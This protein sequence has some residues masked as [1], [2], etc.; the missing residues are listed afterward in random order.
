MASLETLRLHVP[1][2]ALDAFAAA[3]ETAC[4]SVGFFLADEDARLWCVEGVKRPGQ[5]EAELA[6][7]LAIASLVTG[8]QPTLQRSPVEAGGWLER[9]RSAFPEQ[10]VG[11]RFA[12][13]GTHLPPGGTPGRITLVLDAGVAFGSGEHAS[14]RGC[15]RALERVAYRRPAHILDLGC[16]SG[17]LAM[18]ASRLLHRCVLATDIDR[19]SV[20]VA[21]D[22]AARNRL[23]NRVRCRIAAGW[24]PNARR[25]APY[26]LIFANI[27][28]RP[29]CAMARPLAEALA[30][31]GTAILSGL[32][33]RQSRMVLSAHRRVGLALDFNLVEGGWTTLILR[34]R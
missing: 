2:P 17:I 8:V 6:A 28:A 1:E 3:L 7:A 23:K 15:L 12:I 27:L 26:D 20:R 21:R 16:G 14:T 10:R 22:N 9:T 25:E 29:L 19:G 24:Q 33:D 11:R 18:A 32:L 31:G 5:A 13:R 30:P 4:R 34:K